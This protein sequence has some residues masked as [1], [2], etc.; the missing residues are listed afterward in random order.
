MVN[1]DE[2]ASFLT[3]FVGSALFHVVLR[4][5]WGAAAPRVVGKSRWVRP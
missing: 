1:R 4:I 2:L 3:V 5:A